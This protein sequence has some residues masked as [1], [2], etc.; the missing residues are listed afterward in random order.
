[1]GEIHKFNYIST[2]IVETHE[3]RTKLL[4]KL[5]NG[6]CLSAKVSDRSFYILTSPLPITPK[7]SFMESREQ[8]HLRG[9]QTPVSIC[10]LSQQCQLFWGQSTAVAPKESRQCEGPLSPALF[11]TRSQPHI[12][13][14]IWANEE[15][16]LPPSLPPGITK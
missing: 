16:R 15:G 11:S 13:P 1:M 14:K 5:L 3:R 6:I 2:H 7:D 4:P 10:S 12:Y 8:D 9:W